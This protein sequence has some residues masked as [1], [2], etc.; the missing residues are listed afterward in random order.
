MFKKRK[1]SKVKDNIMPYYA[2]KMMLRK[3][4]NKYKRKKLFSETFVL[5]KGKHRLN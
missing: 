5:Q 2:K 3:T 1:N 4:Q